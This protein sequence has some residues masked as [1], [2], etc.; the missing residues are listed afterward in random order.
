MEILR[1]TRDDRM[2]PKISIITVFNDYECLKEH[3]L[4][5]LIHQPAHY[6]EL[7]PVDNRNEQYS[8]AAAA[9][10][11]GAE[12]ATGDYYIFVHQDVKFLQSDWM[13]K[14]YAYLESLSDI[15][16][17]GI[18]GLSKVGSTPREQTRNT[19]SHGSNKKDWVLGTE[20]Q[21]PREVQT[22]DEFCIIIPKEIYEEHQFNESL[23]DGWHL[24]AVELCLRIN[25]KTNRRSYVL[26]IETW[27][28]STGMLIRQDYYRTL[29]RIAKEYGPE[30]ELVRTT[31]GIWPLSKQYTH[32][33]KKVAK[34]S[35]SYLPPKIGTL[36]LKTLP[37]VYGLILPM[38]IQ[39][40][41]ESVKEIVKEI[42]IRVRN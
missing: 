23:C 27:H 33:V 24:Y 2:P 29:N 30:E 42:Q 37:L 9:L 5:S 13:S 28:G 35:E 1:Y 12:K 17:A 25:I 4:E 3:L 31:C 8:S 14:I 18:T 10:N 11:A 32:H 26:P 22:V 39:D 40:E 15:G 6:Y 36:V 20:I 34:I 7:I 16:V 21:S 19:L 38:L 41:Y